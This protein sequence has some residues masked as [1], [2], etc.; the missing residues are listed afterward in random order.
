[1]S[2]AGLDHRLFR[3]INSV[4]TCRLF[5]LIMPIVTDPG[6][7]RLAVGLGAVCLAAWLWR[8]REKALRTALSAAAAVAAADLLCY[9][10]LKPWIH[11]LRP[12]F[13]ESG[14]I[15]RAGSHSRFGFP[16]N[17]AANA[18]AAA[19]VLSLA[20]PRWRWVFLL[21]AATVAY[22]RI[23]VGAHFPADVIGG[24]VIGAAFGGVIVAASQ[25][26]WIVVKSCLWGP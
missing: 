19:L 4:W 24:A 23:Y 9:R 2:L 15:L 20:Y 26:R 10:L 18:F 16:S 1:M 12:E 21:S 3:E 5:D 8:E 17:H 13:S 22:S 7:S 11:R 6:K 14:V 25:L